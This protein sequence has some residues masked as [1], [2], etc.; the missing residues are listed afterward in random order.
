MTSWYFE[1]FG[2]SFT[3]AVFLTWLVRWLAVRWQVLDRPESAPDRKQHTRAVPLLG[4]L[5]VILASLGS[6][7]IITA[8]GQIV[9]QDF[10]LKYLIGLTIAAVLLGVG[11][12]L[13]D[14]FGLN[15]SQQIVWPLV[16]TAVVIIA[17]IGITE[18]TNPFGGLLHLVQWEL[19]VF[20][21][22]GI[23]Y[24]LTLWADAFTLVW[25]MGMMYTTKILDGLDG[26]VSGLGVI[27]SII[28]FLLTLRPEVNQPAVALLGLGLAGAALG[29]LL[30]NWSPAS[31]FLGESG[32]LYIGFMLGVLA[33]IS[34][35]KIATALLIMGLPILD[36]AWVIFQRRFIQKT[37][38]WRTADRSHLHFRLLDAG[39]SV[40]QSV[41]LLYGVIAL[42][43]AST[44]F[45][46]G[47]AKLWALAGVGLVLIG[48]VSWVAR[49][50]RRQTP[51]SSLS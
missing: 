4:G 8:Q 18:I 31:I 36:L 34:G 27:G 20:S 6:W 33:I 38:P 16:A 3:L 12:A 19:P 13:D 41:W 24:Q 17:G 1:A 51:P 42:F 22:H 28:I 48:L 45:F 37:S 47:R 29:F 46:S 11:G 25:L 32:A 5:A 26:L 14:R 39:L 49:R 23:A 2:L 7:W 50:I 10:P 44:L 21:W 15:P 40:R 43:G 35:G 30:F 9:S